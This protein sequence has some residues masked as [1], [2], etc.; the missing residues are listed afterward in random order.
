MILIYTHT[1][2][3]R[4]QY[5]CEFI[6]QEQLG[7]AF[8]ITTREERFTSAA[9]PKINYSHKDFPGV[10]KIENVLLLFEK[11]VS[12]QQIECTI[13]NSYKVF[14]NTPGSDFPFDIFAAV[15]Y[16]LSRYEE[17]LPH[18]KDMYGRYAHENSLAFKEGFLNQPLINTWIK[19]FKHYLK[20]I[21]P[22][23]QFKL[24]TFNFLPTYDIDIAWSYK[25]KGLARNIAGFIRNPSHE[26]IKVLKDKKQDPF[27]SYLFLN[28][29]HTQY[30]INPIY[31][32]L[33]ASSKR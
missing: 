10:F 16:L 11:G 18:D 3:S 5:V 7:I 21:F 29:L 2:S 9:L 28:D 17:Y 26:R 14:Y 24:L 20:T 22:T 12:P 33:V 30:K 4:L 13:S 27:D 31:F 19:D 8:E 1:N 32:F 23:L 25:N 15:F 6:F